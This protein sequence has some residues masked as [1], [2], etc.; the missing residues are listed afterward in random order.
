VEA[1]GLKPLSPDLERAYPGREVG[2]G[3][4]GWNRGEQPGEGA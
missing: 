2:R 1:P 4:V 3:A